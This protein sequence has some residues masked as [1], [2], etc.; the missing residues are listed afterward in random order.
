MTKEKRDAQILI[1][2]PQWVKDKLQ[3]EADEVQR[4]LSDWCYIRLTGRVP[5]QDVQAKRRQ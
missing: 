1:R 5:A 4:S 3:K 2:V